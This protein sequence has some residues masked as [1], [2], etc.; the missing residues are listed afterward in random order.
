MLLYSM[1]VQVEVQLLA[2]SKMVV[3]GNIFYQTDLNT[4]VNWFTNQVQ[5]CI[6][7]IV[8]KDYFTSGEILTL[9]WHPLN[10]AYGHMRVNYDNDYRSGE[11]SGGKKA[12]KTHE[13]HSKHK[14]P[15]YEIEWKR[16]ITV[17]LLPLMCQLKFTLQLQKKGWIGLHLEANW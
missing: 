8:L 9:N 17:T 3:L 5:S 15:K 14:R 12:E 16:P 10:V 7:K 6:L 4:L 11:T 2:V 13:Q 1:P